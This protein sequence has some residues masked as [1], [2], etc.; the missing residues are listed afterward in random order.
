LT[1]SKDTASGGK[2]QKKNGVQTKEGKRK[3][4]AVEPQRPVEVHTAVHE[5][6]KSAIRGKVEPVSRKFFPEEDE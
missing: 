2:S 4:R 1:M 3:C 5:T 6:I